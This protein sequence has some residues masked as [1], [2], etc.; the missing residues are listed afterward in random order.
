LAKEVKM[1]TQFILNLN[2]IRK[3]AH[4]KGGR[5]VITF[6]KKRKQAKRNIPVENEKVMQD[7]LNKGWE[8]VSRKEAA[9][10]FSKIKTKGKPSPGSGYKR[11]ARAKNPVE[12]QQLHDIAKKRKEKFKKGGFVKKAGEKLYPWTPTSKAKWKKAKT[13]VKGWTSDPK[14][15]K[16][17]LK[18]AKNI[19]QAG[20]LLRLTPLSYA[21]WAAGEKAVVTGYK[22]YQKYKKKKSGVKHLG[23]KEGGLVK[24]KSARI[25]TRGWGKVIK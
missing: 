5:K 4:T 25:A 8:P 18:A 11:P 15:R 24:P 19:N 10:H 22:K 23:L 9:E 20:K 1:V 21:A 7:A 16:K 12:E 6:I 2:K 3:F 13:S 14:N 17:L